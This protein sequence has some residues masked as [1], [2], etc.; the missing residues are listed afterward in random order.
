VEAEGE[1]EEGSSDGLGPQLKEILLCIV[2]KWRDLLCGAT[3]CA[4]P[5]GV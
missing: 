4:W 1:E 3:A 2:R 5:A